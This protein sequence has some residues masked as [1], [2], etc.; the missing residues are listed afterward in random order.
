MD[1]PNI[2]ILMTD[3]QRYDSLGCYGAEFAKTPNL[4]RVAGEGAC[5]EHCIINNPVCT[6]S[7]ASLWTGKE[8]PGHGVY[9]LYDNL[10]KDEV[11]F[12]ER[13]RA[14][15]YQTGLIGKLHVSSLPLESEERHPHDGFDV[16]E[17]CIEGCLFMEAP[18][19]SYA[20][21]LE[22]HNRDL[23]ARL[24]REARGVK[25]IPRAF[26]F[27]HWAA[28]RTIHFLRNRDPDRPFFCMMSL[29]DPHNPYDLYPPDLE[30]LFRR[31][32]IPPPLPANE[33]EPAELRR[34]RARCYLGPFASQSPDEIGEMRRGYHTAIA[35]ADHEHGRVL[36]ALE[37]EGL[38]D[39]T[40]VIF[41]SDHGDMMG[42]HGLL[43]KGAYFY[44]PCTRV[45][46]L[47]RWPARL[48]A[49]A[50]P[51]AVVQPHDLAATV[52]A[53]AGAPFEQIDAWMPA[54]RDLLPLARGAVSAVH[55]YAVCLYRNTSIDSKRRYPD[56]PLHAAMIRDERWKLNVYH[57]AEGDQG[58]L[59]D[60]RA[61]PLE[62][63]NLWDDPAAAGE[64]ARLRAALDAWYT[65]YAD[66]L[67]AGS[68]GGETRLAPPP[69]RRPGQARQGG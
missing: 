63:S 1:Q 5:F 25:H 59:F 62:R 64:R 4:D 2:L 14:L 49:G 18:Y 50:R 17:P 32:A 56:P 30:T 10:P 48:P 40:L 28:E 27:S 29:F 33:N 37:R 44:D 3:Q 47:M 6:P 65:R 21:W 34:E 39:N 68:R 24:L 22:E 43:V 38:K 54:A 67:A 57:A 23:Y 20:R 26:H 46:L 60:M 12:S 51:R 7:R 53:A 31:D 15:G 9:R 58:E 13:L 11:L 8:L 16:Y 45:P 61:D 19:Q 55:D 69:P 35:Y 52:L 36:D 66:G 42:D 41:V